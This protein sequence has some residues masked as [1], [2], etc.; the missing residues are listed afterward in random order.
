VRTLA[1]LVA[2]RMALGQPYL[3]LS[4]ILGGVAALTAASALVFR[5]RRVRRWFGIEG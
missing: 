4:L 3:R 2:A 1:A 5:A